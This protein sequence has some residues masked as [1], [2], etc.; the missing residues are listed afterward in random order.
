MDKEANFFFPVNV[1]SGDVGTHGTEWD[2][3][4]ERPYHL[5]DQGACLG[6]QCLLLRG[7]EEQREVVVQMQGRKLGGC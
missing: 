2:G 7:K 3:G 6:S 1:M 4:G 5:E